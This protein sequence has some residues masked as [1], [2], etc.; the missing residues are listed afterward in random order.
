VKRL[1]IFFVIMRAVGMEEETS[2]HSYLFPTQETFQQHKQF[3]E[4]HQLYHRYPHLR[5]VPELT[6]R[7]AGTTLPLLNAFGQDIAFSPNPASP[8]FVVAGYGY[9]YNPSYNSGSTT[10][11]QNQTAIAMLCLARYNYNTLALDTTFNQQGNGPGGVGTGTPGKVVTQFQSNV[12]PLRV[13][14]QPDRLIPPRVDRQKILVVG[15]FYLVTGNPNT[16]YYQIFAARY[17]WDGSL[18]TTYNA[19]GTTPGVATTPVSLIPTQPTITA[20]ISDLA[21]DAAL[22]SDNKLVIVGTATNQLFVLRYNI[23]GTLDT[24]FN[25]AGVSYNF[26]TLPVAVTP[27]GSTPGVVICS[28][29]SK[30]TVNNAG[31][32][33]VGYDNAYAVAIQPDGKI[34]VAGTGSAQ[35]PPLNSS[36]NSTTPGLTAVVD[37]TGVNT[38]GATGV[39]QIILMRF[40]SA[41]VPDNTFGKRI[42]SL[43][44]SGVQ[45]S[46]VAGFNDSAYAVA[47]QTDG[48]ILVAG[49]M[50]DGFGNFNMVLIRYTSTG[51][52]DPLFGATQTLNTLNGVIR[53]P[54]RV[55]L[56]IAQS[57]FSLANDVWV[58]PD[59]KIVISGYNIYYTSIQRFTMTAARYL[60]TGVLDKSFNPTGYPQGFAPA[61][62][63]IPVAYKAPTQPGVQTISLKGLY[64]QSYQMALQPG[65]SGRIW[66][67]GSSFLNNA[68]YEF[69]TTRLSS[70][71]AVEKTFLTPF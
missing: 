22:Q 69:G 14:I 28:I 11:I 47:L 15:Y 43:L 30:R 4:L 58:Q 27:G 45:V 66:L 42:N 10:S 38:I 32:S 29:L 53:I 13:L 34:V 12:F 68:V 36:L 16:N 3:T 61:N 2:S 56:P 5:P 52:I 60:S 71:G 59:G 64:D 55:V 46:T 37:G 33:V 9:Q 70:T 25:A 62:A 6:M 54:G 1:L 63:P 50:A 26:N 39:N 48:K 31:L 41:G 49:S 7:A 67:E 18:D 17:N 8:T 40:T 65:N 24:T 23:D 35:V 20:G 51:I 57:P 44:S 21:Y 19:N